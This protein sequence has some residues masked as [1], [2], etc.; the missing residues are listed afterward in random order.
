MRTVDGKRIATRTQKQ[1]NPRRQ[2]SL[3]ARARWRERLVCQPG[4]A[5][6]ISGDGV[7]KR[8]NRPSE[9]SSLADWP[10]RSSLAPPQSEPL[11]PLRA[12]CFHITNRTVD[13][14]GRI[15]RDFRLNDKIALEEHVEAH[16]KFWRTPFVSTRG[17]RPNK[18]HDASAS[19]HW[20]TSRPHKHP[21]LTKGTCFRRC[22][23]R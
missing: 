15:S 6:K 12:L 21:W 16:K 13:K 4:V 8:L 19:M 3:A 9:T 7:S 20:T 2:R 5:G 14:I 18:K 11:P 1:G 23:Y 10:T 17:L 22:C